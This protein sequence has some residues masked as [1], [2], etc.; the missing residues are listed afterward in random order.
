[1]IDM[2]LTP[3]QREELLR[4][5]QRHLEEGKIGVLSTAPQFGRACIV[6]GR[7]GSS[8][9]GTR[10]GERGRRQ[11]CWRATSAVAVQVDAIARCS[12]TAGSHPAFT[13]PGL[14]SAMPVRSPSGKSGITC[15]WT[16][17]RTAKI[18]AITAAYAISAI[19][20]GGCRARALAH[21]GDIQAG[22]SGC[23]IDRHQW[24]ELTQHQPSSVARGQQLSL[25]TAA[26]SRSATSS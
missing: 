18:V 23:T 1:M 22:D 25:T 26:R 19:T 7:T 6:Y 17:R 8:P 21:M 10:A 11:W 3:D 14:R 13:Y 2:D 24:E 9:Q 15:C 16:S 12:P 20:D 5:L 4:K